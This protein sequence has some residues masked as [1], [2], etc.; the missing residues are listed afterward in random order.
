[1]KD[2]YSLE[3]KQKISAHEAHTYSLRKDGTNLKKYDHFQCPEPDCQLQL[4][5][6]NFGKQT[7]KKQR[8][9]F[10][11]C[12]QQDLHTGQNCQILNVLNRVDYQNAEQI[13]FTLSTPPQ[14]NENGPR[15]RIDP[16]GEIERLEHHSN[17]QRRDEIHQTIYFK[18]LLHLI[19]D[20][21]AI[22]INIDGNA[23]QS[24]HLPCQ[25][26]KLSHKDFENN[27]GHLKLYEGDFYVSSQDSQSLLFNSK[28]KI[29]NS[30]EQKYAPRI[31]FKLS[32]HSYIFQEVLEKTVPNTSNRDIL[33]R[34]RCL[35]TASYYLFEVASK[36][37]PNLNLI[38]PDYIT[39]EFLA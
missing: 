33:V 39:V 30:D 13:S 17:Y 31:K 37:I 38:H 36:R 27:I 28:D 34:V 19:D 9:Y 16:S 7:S 24:T 20:N 11:K 25:I 14:R 10:R 35:A 12:S 18:Q 5:C 15:C 32:N 1:M 4:L 3:L 23:Y 2:A 26:T 29:K 22:P 21:I 8:V 6:T